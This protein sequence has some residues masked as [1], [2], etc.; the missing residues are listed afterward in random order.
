MAPSKVSACWRKAATSRASCSASWCSFSVPCSRSH[1]CGWKGRGE[2][3]PVPLRGAVQS[4][5]EGMQAGG[6]G[7]P[8]SQH[9]GSQHP[10]R[11]CS[12]R[13][14]SAHVLLRCLRRAEMLLLSLLPCF[15]SFWARL[16]S[17]SCKLWN[18]CSSWLKQRQTSACPSCPSCPALRDLHHA[19]ALW[20]SG[21][22]AH[23]W[24]P[25]S[26]SPASSQGCGG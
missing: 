5:G 8:A 6:L 24:S 4:W 1:L 19:P 15:S 26:L 11:P 7:G 3:Q 16:F 14:S 12:A 18:C 10:A 2:R 9:V 22:P 21:S 25:S 20:G 17:S 23:R 13:M